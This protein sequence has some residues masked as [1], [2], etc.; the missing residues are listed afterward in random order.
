MTSP[1]HWQNY[2]YVDTSQRPHDE[3]FEV[4]IRQLVRTVVKIPA[5]NALSAARIVDN[6]TFPLPPAWDWEH[7]PADGWEYIVRNPVTRE[8][9]YRGDAQE[10]T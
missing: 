6:V 4:E 1:Q 7:I 10:L 2:P 9:L 3:E 8:I 5:K